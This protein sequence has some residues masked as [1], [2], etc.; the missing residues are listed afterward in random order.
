MSSLPSS[1][2]TSTAFDSRLDEETRN[3]STEAHDPPSSNVLPFLVTNWLAN[4]EGADGRGELDD[5][6]KEAVDRIRRATSDIAAAFSSLGAFGQSTLVSFS[7]IIPLKFNRVLIFLLSLA[8]FCRYI[9][10]SAVQ[11]PPK[12]NLC[13]Y[14]QTVEW[15]L[16]K[17]NRIYGAG[18]RIC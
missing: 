1:A 13:R 18:H 10:G 6:R 12:F 11:S 4:Y 5:R 8:L 9:I 7:S 17:P 2:S 16:P 15:R 14:A 3:L